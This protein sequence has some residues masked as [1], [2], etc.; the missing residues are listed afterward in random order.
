MQWRSRGFARNGPAV[1]SDQ[2]GTAC[3]THSLGTDMLI[4]RFQG[5]AAG[6]LGQSCSGALR[7]R[8]S[9]PSHLESCRDLQPPEEQSLLSWAV[10]SLVGP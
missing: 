1:L 4:D 7:G 2:Q 3:G 10:C 5:V 6:A 9:W 8:F